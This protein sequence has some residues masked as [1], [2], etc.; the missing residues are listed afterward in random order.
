MDKIGWKWPVGQAE[1]EDLNARGVIE[2]IGKE[3]GQDK[4]LTHTFMLRNTTTNG[5]EPTF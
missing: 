4:N 5:L 2:R 1:N 3:N